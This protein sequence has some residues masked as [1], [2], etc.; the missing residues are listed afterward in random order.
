MCAPA[1]IITA[2][3]DT[4]TTEKTKSRDTAAR[5]ESDATQTRRN[6]VKGERDADFSGLGG[7]KGTDALAGR[8]RGGRCDDQSQHSA[9]GRRER[10]GNGGAALGGIV[11]SPA[12]FG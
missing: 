2:T 8:R 12:A 7:R 1:T 3:T 11:G 6:D 5:R 10:S 9:E 4:T